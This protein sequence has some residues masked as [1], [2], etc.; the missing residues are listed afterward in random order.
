MDTI[1]VAPPAP[2][3]TTE[4]QPG[5]VLRG[6]GLFELHGEEIL[7][8][9][10]GGGKWLV[11]SGTVSGRSYEVRAGVRPERSRCECVGF[12]HHGHCSHVV[13]ATI[14]RK[15]SAVCDECG[16]R[17]LHRELVEVHKDHESLS[18]W[19]GDKLCRHECAGAH[20]VL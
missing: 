9:Y 3:S 19:P 2:E 14:A 5:Y 4:T 8:G 16:G 18:H 15:K 17:F 7:D 13:A 20:G 6:L 11:P 10:Q 1:S 12:G